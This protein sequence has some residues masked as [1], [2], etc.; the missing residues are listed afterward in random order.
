M[1][2]MQQTNLRRTYKHIFKCF[3][4]LVKRFRVLCAVVNE[5][6]DIIIN[7]ISDGRFGI[8]DE[9]LVNLASSYGVP[10]PASI[11]VID[12][13][14]IQGKIKFI[15][16]KIYDFNRISELL[17]LSIS[18]NQHA[19]GGPVSRLLEKMVASVA[20]IQPDTKV[21]VVSSGT[22]ALHLACSFH[23]VLEKKPEMRW[24]TSA[25]SFLSCKAS[26]LSNS[27]VIDSDKK[28]RFDLNSLKELPLESYDGVI[29]TNVFSQMTDWGDVAS[30]CNQNGKKIVIDNAVGLI[31]RV[32]A[33][34][35][36]DAAIEIISAH[37]TK[38]WGVGECGI[39]LCN[40]E[41]EFLMRKLTN[42]GDEA[43]LSTQAASSNF[44]ISDLAAAAIIDRLERMPF[45]GPIY[46]QQQSR[47]AKIINEE[48]TNIKPLIGTTEPKSPRAYAPFLNENPINTDTDTRSI[49]IR[50]YYR[51]LKSEDEFKI[52]C[53][54]SLELYSRILCI[55]N[56]P[57]HFFV[58]SDEIVNDIKKLQVN[59]IQ[60]DMGHNAI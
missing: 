15:E 21:I 29:F 11:E 9:R 39:I 16:N 49:T 51:P 13:P 56:A 35:D 10:Q 14:K 25:F 47:M 24:V 3:V 37:H 17:T 23:S 34:I 52:R 44:K 45:W 6:D 58:S 1:R 36:G 5:C 57:E 41:Q 22:A 20:Q 48:F 26:K 33:P 12:G 43:V 2:K 19:N 46:D 31:D 27:I 40:S 38:P 53:S 28:G 18:T 59:L 30:Y 54:N 55:S 8:R 4:F 50:K 7:S 42:F 60:C 32:T